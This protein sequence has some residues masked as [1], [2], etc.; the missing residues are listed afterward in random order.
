MCFLSRAAPHVP[1][2][3]LTFETLGPALSTPPTHRPAAG[4]EVRKNEGSFYR[5]RKGYHLPFFMDDQGFAAVRVNE[6]NAVIDVYTSNRFTPMYT[7]VLEARDLGAAAA[8]GAK[9]AGARAGAG[10]APRLGHGRRRALARRPLRAA[11]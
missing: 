11:G 2:L 9:G 6:T 5:E 4:S 8:A 3:H 10:A 7:E 1:A